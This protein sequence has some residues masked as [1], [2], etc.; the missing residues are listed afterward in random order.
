RLGDSD[1]LSQG[2]EREPSPRRSRVAVAVVLAMALA[3]LIL[4]HLPHHHPPARPPQ[5]A[6]SHRPPPVPGAQAGLPTEPDEIIGPTAGWDASVQ[7]PVTGP[8]PHW[9]QPA[10]GRSTP[11]GG[12][13]VNPAGY[14]FTR[15]AGG[16]AVRPNPPGNAADCDGCSACG[17]CST[18]PLPVYFLSSGGSAHQIGQ[19]NAV[20]PGASAGTLW[21]TTYAQ[22]TDPARAGGTAQE[23][24]TAGQPLRTPVRL[25]AGYVLAQATV[26]GLLL[27]GRITDWLWAPPPP[28]QPIGGTTTAPAGHSYA[29]VIA[30]SPAQ[31]A[32]TPSCA[33]HCRLE[34]RDLAAGR[35]T[36]IALPAGTAIASGAFSPDGKLLA[37]QVRSA[38]A[39]D[40]GASRTRLEVVTV[41]TG[42]LAP[43][44]GTSAS[45]DALDGFGW[46][47]A[48]N[49][50]VAELSL[51]TRVQ[52]ASWQPG[53]PRPAVVVI[54]PAQNLN[55]TSMIVG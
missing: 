25:P 26:R 33:T 38:S 13:P 36:T 41:A 45:S 21:V 22:G 46:P 40:S 55:L 39:G 49:T 3:A 11:I 14:L 42:R 2:E 12:L 32:W 15:I 5:A 50:L 1:I 27:A 54:R 35:D 44:P 9:F 28:S 30:A 53:A 34:I 51:T 18:Q 7:L 48:G 31:I 16:W 4:T 6:A 20:A 24:S 43:V 10:T 52:V 19:A 47:A 17:N 29:G 8:Q 37:V 23:V